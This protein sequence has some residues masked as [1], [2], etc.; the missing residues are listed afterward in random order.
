MKREHISNVSIDIQA[1]P[2]AV[3]DALVT[4]AIAKKY[5]FGADVASDW[6]E[7]SP[8]TF[9]G[10]F[11]GNKYLEKG[12]LLTIIPGS[13]LQY[14]HWSSLESLPDEPENYR[15]W[16]F[17]IEAK[18]GLTQLSVTE[19]NIPT[20]MQQKRSDEFWAGVLLTIRQLLEV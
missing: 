6:K 10:E 8:I 5:F 13:R 3:W 12:V 18:E 15:T 4:P 9:T 16:T 14:T 17:D 7:G 20:E 11:G 1:T 2:E 19:D